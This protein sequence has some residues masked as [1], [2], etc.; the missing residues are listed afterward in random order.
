MER[1]RWLVNTGRDR[2]KEDGVG[3]VV[4]EHRKGWGKEDG[5]GKVVGEHMEGRWGN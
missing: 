2:G 4:G 5:E 1:E 3:K